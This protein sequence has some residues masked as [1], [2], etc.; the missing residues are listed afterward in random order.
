MLTLVHF[1]LDETRYAVP[2]SRVI[3]VV[4][5]VLVT[6]LSGVAPPVLGVLSYRG[7]PI[8]AVDLRARLMLP[9]R[10]PGCDDHFIIAESARRHVALVVERVDGIESIPLADVLPSP[11]P[12]P[13]VA[14]VVRLE[15]GFML[16]HDLDAV[17]SLAEERAI[18]AAL[19][20][21][22]ARA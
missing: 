6:P 11:S 15:G 5:R 12:S 14:G 21:L 13:H 20:A 9:P 2:A 8:S 17:L 10:A 3:E 19:G 1:K 22:E 16:I 18:D 4:P 7:A